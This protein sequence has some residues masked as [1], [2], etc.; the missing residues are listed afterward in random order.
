MSSAR[1]AFDLLAL[2]P[3]V[4]ARAVRAAYARAIKSFDPDEDPERFASLRAARDAALAAAGTTP[5]PPPEAPGAPAP[6]PRDDDARWGVAPAE[7]VAETEA[8]RPEPAGTLCTVPLPPVERLKLVPPLLARAPMAGLLHAGPPAPPAP[9][10]PAAGERRLVLPPLDFS[11]PVINGRAAAGQLAVPL[12]PDLIRAMMAPH[13][14]GVF[15]LLFPDRHFS[16]EPLTEA[17]RAA[18]AAHLEAILGDG[19]LANIEFFAQVERWLA[20]LFADAGPRGAPFLPLLAE[21]FNWHPDADR[22]DRPE[23]VHAVIAPGAR[24]GVFAGDFAAKSSVEPR[25]ARI[26]PD[27]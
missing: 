15:P 22:I 25:V 11:A 8:A 23:E 26:A 3:P 2:T 17:E 1:W 27:G 19:R 6:L 21:R 7:P 13:Y 24:S 4:D 14:D 20:D 5:A 12:D 10:P 16:A 9:P 18:L